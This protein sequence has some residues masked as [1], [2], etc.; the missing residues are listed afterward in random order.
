MTNKN[1]KSTLMGYLTG[2]FAIALSMVG[3]DEA[4]AA[5][6]A[7]KPSGRAKTPH[8]DSFQWA[9]I[10]TPRPIEGLTEESVFSKSRLDNLRPR[11]KAYGGKEG[12][13]AARD[14][15]LP[16]PEA[17]T[18][19]QDPGNALMFL[20]L[21][22]T[23]RLLMNLLHDVAST[24]L[25]KQFADAAAKHDVLLCADKNNSGVLGFYDGG[26]GIIAVQT[27]NRCDKY[28]YTPGRGEA[29]D[30]KG[31]AYGHMIRVLSEEISHSAQHL[32]LENMSPKNETRRWAADRKLWD[33]AIEAQAKFFAAWI[34]LQMADSETGTNGYPVEWVQQTESVEGRM[35]S[36]L[37]EILAAHGAKELSKRPDLQLPVFLRFFESQATMDAYFPQQ[38]DIVNSMKGL[39]RISDKEFADAFGLVPG[40]DDG[41]FRRKS[42]LVSNG[43][44]REG[45]VEAMPSGPM[46]DWFEAQ[47]AARKKGRV[48]PPLKVPESPAVCGSNLVQRIQRL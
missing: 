46:K 48:G 33:L 21:T 13:K 19:L 31:Y 7:G 20:K 18:V 11:L 8:S 17:M 14:V 35:T 12:E 29:I 39:D 47:E 25:G 37:R 40:G 10:W 24:R 23:Q 34:L 30:G 5:S 27:K 43:H 26:S 32:L 9:S 22:P 16:L 45:L 6:P 3:G 36:L 2:A 1:L 41:L 15:C 38:L 28:D 4:M 44:L 42:G